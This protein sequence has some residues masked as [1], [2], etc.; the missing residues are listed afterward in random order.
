MKHKKTNVKTTSWEPVEQWYKTIVK[1]EG[2]Y[3]HKHIILPGIS[4]LAGNVDS[5]LDLA[6]GTGVLA[7]HI[8]PTTE[9]VG[10]DISPSFI[11]EAVKRD[12]LTNHSYIVA[13]VTK[14]LNLNIKDF[15]LATIV[16]AAQNMQNPLMAFRNASHHLVK[17][18]KFILILN[19]PCFRVPRQSSWGVDESKKIQYRRIDRYHTSFEVPIQ[20]HPGQGAAS[21]MTWT[22][23]YPLF[24]FVNWLH[25]SG[26]VI[27][28]ME[29]WCSDKES[30]GKNSKMENKSRSEIPLFL[31][32][33]AAKY[34]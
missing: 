14:P 21:P 18:G 5:V 16:L 4:K 20:A 2:H 19:H 11:K 31:A 3:Y 8:P 15:N 23:H 26:F 32:I 13:D 17:G 1:D 22:F 24:Q 29:E 12:K 33:R 28:I 9:Y 27:E 7:A 25:E 10:V 30:T 34:K 6:C